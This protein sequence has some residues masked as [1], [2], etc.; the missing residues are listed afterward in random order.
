MINISSLTLTRDG[1]NQVAIT[2]EPIFINLPETRYFTGVYRIL[3]TDMTGKELGEVAFHLDDKNIWEFTGDQF[4]IEEQEQIVGFIR[5]KEPFDSVT[6]IETING[7]TNHYR[8]T[9]NEGHFGVEKDGIFIAVIEHQ[10]DW[11][12]SEGK[13]LGDELFYKIV[14]KIEARNY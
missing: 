7:I 4:D 8:I 13:P 10:E 14:S 1:G 11:L 9:D 12:Q 3:E 2:I 6:F 5:E